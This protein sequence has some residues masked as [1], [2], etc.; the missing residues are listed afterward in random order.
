MGETLWKFFSAANKQS[1]WKK[2]KINMKS[3]E[4]SLCALLL[5]EITQCLTVVIVH[6]IYIS[7]SYNIQFFCYLLLWCFFL[8][9]VNCCGR[10]LCFCC[11]CLCGCCFETVSLCAPRWPWTWCVAPGWPAV[12]RP[13]ASVSKVLELQTPVNMSSSDFG[14]KTQ[15]FKESMR[16]G[17][18]RDDSLTRILFLPCSSYGAC[19]SLPSPPPFF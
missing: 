15:V 7:W 8:F 5:L 13:A 14:L 2:W 3:T 18:I 19:L 17:I 12:Y 16:Q 10:E 1:E 4:D 9:S 6:R 11:T